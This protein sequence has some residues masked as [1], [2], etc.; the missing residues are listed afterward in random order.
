MDKDHMRDEIILGPAWE[1][2]VIEAERDKYGAT[3]T[4]CTIVGQG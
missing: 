4:K 1:R 3:I 2:R